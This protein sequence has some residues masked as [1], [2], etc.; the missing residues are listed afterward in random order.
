MTDKHFPGILEGVDH[1]GTGVAEL[2]LKDGLAVLAPP[3]LA[4]C[5]M[6][7]SEF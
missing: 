1:H 6:I 2:D 4:N 3:F 7:L 5:S